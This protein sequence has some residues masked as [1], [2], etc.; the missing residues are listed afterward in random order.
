MKC[1]RR[2]EA[3]HVSNENISIKSIL[4]ESDEIELCV[5]SQLCPELQVRIDSILKF[6]IFSKNFVKI[7]LVAGRVWG[8]AKWLGMSPTAV[9]KGTNSI[10][11]SIFLHNRMKIKT[12]DPREEG[13]G[14]C[15]LKIRYCDR[16]IFNI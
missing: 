9:T 2:R 1:H 13:G 11:W 14:S 16:Q 7:L 4:L 12:I 10:I 6:Y 15:A 3:L 8:V 5:E